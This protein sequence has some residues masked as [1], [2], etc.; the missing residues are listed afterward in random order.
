MSPFVI[1][2]MLCKKKI[3]SLSLYMFPY[4]KCIEMNESLIMLKTRVSML[5]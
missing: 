5:L 4:F 2:V 3:L 1:F